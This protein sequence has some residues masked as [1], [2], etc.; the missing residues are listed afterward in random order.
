MKHFYRL[1]IFCV[2]LNVQNLFAQTY[3]YLQST[4]D[5]NYG[6]YLLLH[7]NVLKIG[8]STTETDRAKNMIKIGDGDYIQI[9]EWE[10][11]DKLSFKATSYNFTNGDVYMNSRLLL[12]YDKRFIIGYGNSVNSRLELFSN[13][14]SN[15]AFIDFKE[16]LYFRG[17]E[18]M[19]CPLTLQND[20][21]VFINLR[22]TSTP[23]PGARHTQGYKLAVNGGI[24]CEEV[25]V[26][27]DVPEADYVFEKDYEL[28][29][30]P[31][32]EQFVKANK[33]LPNIPSAAEFKT[34]GYKV[35]EMD[36]MLLR[37]VEELSLHLIELNKRIEALEKENA[38]LKKDRNQ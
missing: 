34:N 20:G 1:L 27:K 10:A 24:L 16:N 17:L 23:G 37:K 26:I 22:A 32:L 19:M 11:D 7:N 4:T 12:P 9:G 25:K 15:H 30:L 38:D 29:S 13:S 14:T 33:H 21:C 8:N 18:G 6:N 35:G 2:L 3:R 36:E 31:K 5:A 28:L